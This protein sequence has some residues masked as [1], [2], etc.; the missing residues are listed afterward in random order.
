M[1][2]VFVAGLATVASATDVKSTPDSVLPGI[3]TEVALGYDIFAGSSTHSL[4][5]QVFDW[6]WDKKNNWNWNSNVFAYPDQVTIQSLNECDENT[7]ISDE[8]AMDFSSTLKTE[9]N[10]KNGGFDTGDIDIG[11][12]Y[13]NFSLSGTVRNCAMFGKSE[14]SVEYRAQASFKRTISATAR[15]L[16]KAYKVTLYDNIDM[17][18]ALSAGFVQMVKEFS[19]EPSYENA[20]KMWRNFGTHYL[21]EVGLGGV[22]ERS[23]YFQRN[24][25]FETA[26]SLFADASANKFDF[27]FIHSDKAEAEVTEETNAKGEKSEVFKSATRLI[28][29]NPMATTGGEFCASMSSNGEVYTP[30]ILAL[31][32]LVPLDTLFDNI[33]GVEAGTGQKMADF[34]EAKLRAGVDC[35]HSDLHPPLTA[36]VVNTRTYEWEGAKD[37]AGLCLTQEEMHADDDYRVHVKVTDFID[38]SQ[39][40]LT[41]AHFPGWA[42]RTGENSWRLDFE[43]CAKWSNGTLL[44][45]GHSGMENDRRYFSFYFKVKEISPGSPVSVSVRNTSP[46]GT[47]ELASGEI[48]PE[49]NGFALFQCNIELMI[50]QDISITFKKG[51]YTVTFNQMS[52]FWPHT[53]NSM[54][55]H[56]SDDDTFTSHGQSLHA[57]NDARGMYL[58]A[59]KLK[60]YKLPEH[61]PSK[62]MEISKNLGKLRKLVKKFKQRLKAGLA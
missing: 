40:T 4:T 16:A 38:V 62:L 25:D 32:K 27:F 44:T 6:T 8:V 61:D 48:P 47:Y 55:T 3:M 18:P 43:P 54:A 12:N 56:S 5:R 46:G 41:S 29:G 20:V 36:C 52:Q 57:Q 24:M 42:M 35:M 17:T 19:A 26:S 30:V 23:M 28:G 49:D 58:L 60:K 7:M 21:M 59:R 39:S 9:A 10:I 11:V 51:T 45:D 1:M 2:N 50:M 22:A 13:K 14:L 33:P 15:V 53:C 37:A 34:I 31:E